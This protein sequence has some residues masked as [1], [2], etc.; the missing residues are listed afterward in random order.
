MASPFASGIVNWRRTYRPYGGPSRFHEAITLS[1]A[2]HELPIGSGAVGGITID[3][4]S[5]G[6]TLVELSASSVHTE[7]SAVSPGSSENAYSVTQPAATVSHAG[8]TK[9]SVAISVAPSSAVM[10]TM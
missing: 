8:P 9:S 7:Y 1:D 4:R 5:G 2:A 10:V 6:V 3:A